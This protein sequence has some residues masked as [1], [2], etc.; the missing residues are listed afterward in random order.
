MTFT[1]F[2]E[3]SKNLGPNLSAGVRIGVFQEANNDK[4]C[5]PNLLESPLLVV[6]DK[7]ESAYVVIGKKGLDTSGLKGCSEVTLVKA[8][9]VGENGLLYPVFVSRLHE[10]K[11]FDIVWTF[12]SKVV[13]EGM[14]DYSNQEG[15]S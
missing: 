1:E 10:W 5:L 11:K 8:A 12:R 6:T 15:V 7:H 3:M 14:E 9:D 4:L 2:L 13:S